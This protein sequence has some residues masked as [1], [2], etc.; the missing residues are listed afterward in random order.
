RFG[1]QT[2]DEWQFEH[3]GLVEAPR[4]VAQHRPGDVGNAVARLVKQLRRG[5]AKLHG[6]VHLNLDAPIGFGFDLLDPGRDRLGRNRGL[7]RQ[8]LVQ[9]QGHGFL[10]KSA[11]AQQTGGAEGQ[12]GKPAAALKSAHENLLQG[13]KKKKLKWWLV[14]NQSSPPDQYPWPPA[15]GGSKR[16]AQSRACPT[17]A[18]RHRNALPAVRQPL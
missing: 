2:R 5:A 12:A 8:K 10:R 15:P 7:R 18:A 16:P 9:S 17:S 11:G 13:L 6:A 1:R 14:V 3:F 4:G